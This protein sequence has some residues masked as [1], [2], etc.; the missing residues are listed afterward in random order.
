MHLRH[1]VSSAF[2]SLGLMN[3]G[4]WTSRLLTLGLLL[5]VLLAGGF[6]LIPVWVYLF[7]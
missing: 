5:A 3:S 1:G 6:A 2:Q 7:L 4:V